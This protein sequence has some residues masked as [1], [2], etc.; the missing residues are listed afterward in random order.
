VESG[1]GGV[2]AAEERKGESRHQPSC[3]LDCVTEL[4]SSKLN[5]VMNQIR[6]FLNGKQISEAIRREMASAVADSIRKEGCTSDAKA[7]WRKH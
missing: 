6:F 1:G 3:C 5:E 2:D 7:S 4:L